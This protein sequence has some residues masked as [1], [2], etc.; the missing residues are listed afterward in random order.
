MGVKI[1]FA[2]GKIINTGKK[3]DHMLFFY[4]EHIEMD[5]KWN[6]GRVSH[7]DSAADQVTDL[8]WRGNLNPNSLIKDD[9][10]LLVDEYLSPRKLVSR[11]P[12]F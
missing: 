12:A 3:S 10:E 6:T 8:S 9:G 11:H 7:P 1:D 5:L 4:S 2:E